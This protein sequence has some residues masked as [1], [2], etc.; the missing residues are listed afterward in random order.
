MQ[1]FGH[2]LLNNLLIS[3]FYTIFA[4]MF[5][6]HCAIWIVLIACCV[7]GLSCSTH[8]PDKAQ[9]T[10]A[11]ADSLWHEGKMYGTDEGDSLSIAQAYGTLARW[12][13]F[14]PDEYAHACY[15]YGRLLRAQDDPVAAME[16]FI[17]A[18]HSRTNDYHI[19]GRVYSNM[20]SI[21]HLSNEY[22]LSYDMYER[23]ADMYMHNG[24]TLLYYYGLYRMA[25]ELAEQGK[26][27]DC[28]A[29][30]EQIQ[31]SK[32]S[33]SLLMAHCY[34]A[35]AEAYLQGRQY[36]TAIYYAHKALSI[37][38]S[39]TIS[40]LQLAQ[41]YSFLGAKDSAT[42]YAQDV[43]E[44]TTELSAI[45]NVLYILTQDVNTKDINVV[46]QAAADRSDVHK[47]IEK[48]Q[49][50]LSQA[51][52]LLEQSLNKPNYYIY[53]I[54]GSILL[55]VIFIIIGVALRNIYRKRKKI[56]RSLHLQRE[57][58]IALENKRSDYQQQRI[59]ELKVICS[60]LRKNKNLKKELD[61]DNYDSMC[62]VVNARLY[63]IVD[64]LKTN[65]DL[66]P[67]DIR[68]CILVLL[69]LSYDEIA[70]ML[71]LSPNSIAKLKSLTAHKLG[72]SMK[73]L[74]SKLVQIACQNDW[75]M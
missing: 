51:V 27:E 61:W 5:V 68:I 31:Q 40:K 4:A 69:E 26:G 18:T 8:V 65:Q 20:G 23:C 9:A 30:L 10:V 49:G 21:C 63:G 11:T 14:Y 58:Q 73:N 36:D 22:A 33:D 17:N 74:Y 55:G 29:I 32:G 64:K 16:C 66:T 35:Y 46:R 56:K 12:Q 19:L 54:I 72:T 45:D 60:N 25:F 53:V 71:N 41:A 24:D 1:T 6:R 34:I 48:R 50:R 28:N 57:H 42:Y 2:F 38:G 44:G 59:K 3:K 7:G 15:H 13:R 47:L 43:L 62:M 67:N 75:N 52:L 70:N 39:F 37:E